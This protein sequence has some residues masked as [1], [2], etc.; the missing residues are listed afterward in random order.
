MR[1]FSHKAVRRAGIVP[2]TGFSFLPSAAQARAIDARMRGSLAASL[3]HIRDQACGLVAFDAAALDR[4]IARMKAGGRYPASTFALYAEIVLALC[5]GEN[6]LAESLFSALVAER[7]LADRWRLLALDD[8]R[9]AAHVERLKGFMEGDVTAP[10]EMR[11]PPPDVASS[12]DRRFHASYR[13]MATAIPD[14]AAEFDALVSDVVMVVGDPAAKYQFDGG[15]CYM[16]WGGLFLNAT[17]HERDIALVEVMAHESA[18]MFLYGC[19]CEEALVENDDSA[20]YRSPLRVDLRPMDGIYHATFVSARM[21]WAMSRLMESGLLDSDGVAFA[22]AA[23]AADRENFWAGHGVVV[24]DG[25]LTRTGATVM[26]A[27]ADY[28]ASA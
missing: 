6:H 24:A 17:S 21:H 8:P 5:E 2:M 28:M 14:L 12:F 19:A 15:S 20:L 26:Q 11:P 3:E 7:P 22:D 18:H 4:L 13:L 27:A 1:S 16:L 9:L 25:Q 10:F 23:R